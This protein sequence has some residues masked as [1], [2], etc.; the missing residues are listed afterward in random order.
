[1]SNVAGI[2]GRELR[3]FD[4][5]LQLGIA[6]GRVLSVSFP[7]TVDVDAETEH[8]LL[9]RIEG[10]LSGEEDD[11]TDVTVALTVPTPQREILQMLRTVPYGDTV[12]M[13]QLLRMTP[14]DHDPEAELSTVRN[15]L[16]GNPAPILIPS[17]RVSDGPSALPDEI[18]RAVRSVEGI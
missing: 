16:A 17:H 10:Y 14:G 3:G 9:D 13:E 18:A 11:F 2:Y 12:S 4:R 7:P 1:M 8:D 15:A 5:S 6:Q